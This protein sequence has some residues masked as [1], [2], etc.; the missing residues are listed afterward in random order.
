MGTKEEKLSGV[1]LKG[2]PPQKK[3]GARIENKRRIEVHP[4]ETLIRADVNLL[5]KVKA[6]LTKHHFSTDPCQQR[7][8]LTDQWISAE[9]R[10]YSSPRMAA[11]RQRGHSTPPRCSPPTLKLVLAS[12]SKAYI[13]C[14]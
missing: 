4:G 3:I 10:L 11:R 13:K 9:S 7:G 1:E 14:L 12:E 6:A 8:R 2:N 5:R